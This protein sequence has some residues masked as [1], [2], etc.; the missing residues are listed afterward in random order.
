MSYDKFLNEF[1]D[2]T[3]FQN[4]L[5]EDSYEFNLETFK[6]LKSLRKK[7]DY[8]DRTLEFLGKGM[9]RAVYELDSTKVI[10]IAL[11]DYEDILS[12]NQ[13]EVMG[14]RCLGEMFAPKLYE[15]GRGFEWIISEKVSQD[16]SAMQNAISRIV[17]RGF[18]LDDFWN[19]LSALLT[20]KIPP[21]M[22]EKRLLAQKLSESRWFKT[23]EHY[24]D[25][26]NLQAK[27][28]HSD[29]LGVNSKGNLVILDLGFFD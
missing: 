25:G 15:V 1:I 29:N 7:L 5:L 21:H 13:A 3:D 18:T 6:N 11:S 28:L 20:D 12:Q 22:L 10:K 2:Y 4:L 14:S 9:A 27:D 24:I 19:T 16:E 17:G 8:A 26:C 23:L